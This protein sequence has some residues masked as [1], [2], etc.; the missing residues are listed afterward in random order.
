VF[1]KRFSHGAAQASVISQC[2]FCAKDWER[3][4]AQAVCG[5]CGIEVLLCRDC[6]R[7]KPP[8]PK[9]KLRCVLC[10]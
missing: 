10:K 9:D 8:P 2:V 5:R 3:Y 1:D 7:S 4:Q 6:Q